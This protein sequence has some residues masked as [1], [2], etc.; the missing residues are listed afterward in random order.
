VLLLHAVSAGGAALARLAPRIL[1]PS[2]TEQLAVELARVQSA[3][4]ALAERNRLAR[5]LHDSVGHALTVTTLQAGAAARVLDTDPA[6]VARALDAIAEVGRAALEDLDHVLGLLRDGGEGARGPQPGLAD[7]D[8]LLDRARA[9]G[10]VVAVERQ[11]PL[12]A[13]P[14]AVSREA[15][16]IVQEALTNALRHAGQVPVTVRVTADESAVELEV[17]NP[18]GAGGGRA[19]VG[20]RG[21]AGMRERVSV[22]R[23]ELA[24]GPAGG[25]WRV[26]ARLPLPMIGSRPGTEMMSP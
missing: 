8:V 20:G 13:V 14:R 6:F 10:L 16:R 18:L 1:G 26:A 9:T 23:G 22:L 12:A 17:T 21:L 5:E 19:R 25:D 2:R 11:G 3:E 24:A 4:R 7:L 15:Y